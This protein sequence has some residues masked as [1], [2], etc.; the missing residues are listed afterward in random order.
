MRFSFWLCSDRKHNGRIEAKKD[1]L[2]LKR[3]AFSSPFV[4]FLSAEQ[5]VPHPQ[6]K[7]PSTFKKSIAPFSTTSLCHRYTLAYLRFQKYTRQV[8]LVNL[9]LNFA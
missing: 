9:K 4:T 2:N 7:A 6:A 1:A 8:F 3:K 5:F